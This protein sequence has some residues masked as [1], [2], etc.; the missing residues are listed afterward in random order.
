MNKH[1]LFNMVDGIY[2]KY[3]EESEMEYMEKKDKKSVVMTLLVVGAIAATIVLAIGLRIN[4][5]NLDNQSLVGA[6][7][8]NETTEAVEKETDEI[9]VEETTIDVIQSE[10]AE[11]TESIE[12][13]VEELVT[14]AITT[15][16]ATEVNDEVFLNDPDRIGG[17][18]ANVSVVSA[19]DIPD[20]IILRESEFYDQKGMLWYGNYNGAEIVCC[21]YTNANSIN[22]FQ[23]WSFLFRGVEKTYE[24]FENAMTIHFINTG[25]PGEDIDNHLD[26]A[27][28]GIDITWNDN[29]IIYDNIRASAAGQNIDLDDYIPR[30]EFCSLIYENNSN[31][32][33]KD[34]YKIKTDVNELENDLY[35]LYKA[36]MIANTVYVIYPDGTTE[37]YCD[38]EVN[39][40]LVNRLLFPICY[41][42]GHDSQSVFA[43]AVMNL[44]ERDYAK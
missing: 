34:G 25:I 32:Y 23:G 9:T 21:D 14:E 37:L 1:D 39:S 15:E 8:E 4:R 3:L 41:E 5:I 27:Y 28:M 20:S 11:T 31:I 24:P 36:A 2:D 19:L 44:N 6:L 10:V 17:W 13:T 12:A 7:V 30:Y 35:K 40:D 29:K 33:L 16:F 18:S 22:K 43:N 42:E 26:H 38:D